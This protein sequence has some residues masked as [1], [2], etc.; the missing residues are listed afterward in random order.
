MPP[1]RIILSI[2]MAGSDRLRLVTG[3]VK[4]MHSFPCATSSTSVISCPGPGLKADWAGRDMGARSKESNKGRT[5]SMTCS[6][7]ALPT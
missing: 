2:C 3:T 6:S 7:A 1:P 4:P 5:A